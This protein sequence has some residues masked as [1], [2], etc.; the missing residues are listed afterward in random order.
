[1]RKIFFFLF[2]LVLVF[3]VYSQNG[4]ITEV[5]GDVEIKPATA[6]AYSRAQVGTQI[7]RDTVI[8]TGFRSTA[9]ITI[10][11]TTLTVRPLT[12]LTLAEI[13]SSSAEENLNIDLETGRVRVAVKPPAGTRANTTVQTPSAT[14]SVRGTEGEIMDGNVEMDN[15]K[16]IFQGNDG[17][18]VVLSSDGSASTLN[19]DGGAIPPNDV[20][21]GNMKPPGPVGTGTSGE[22]PPGASSGVDAGDIGL[23][24]DWGNTD[25]GGGSGGGAKGVDSPR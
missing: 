10:G 12:R 16:I 23:N 3:S 13:Q 11:S 24:I 6:S 8:S 20:K 17:L 4:V 1:M 21:S 2:V 18:A 25:D 15:G 19:S 9:V 22:S 7:A 14:A 5:T